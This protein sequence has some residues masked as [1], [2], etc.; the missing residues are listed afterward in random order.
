MLVYEKRVRMVLVL[1]NPLIGELPMIRPEWKQYMNSMMELAKQN[2][3]TIE[4]I[5]VCTQDT[6]FSMKG[7]LTK[8][9]FHFFHPNIQKYLVDGILVR[10]CPIC[11]YDID[12]G[13]QYIGK[14]QGEFIC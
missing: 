5:F 2:D 8:N 1:D 10:Q 4:E 9:Y 3:I 7:G 13:A 14:N 12:S 6:P 11:K